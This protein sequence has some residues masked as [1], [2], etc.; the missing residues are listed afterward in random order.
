MPYSGIFRLEFESS[1]VIF[2]ISTLEFAKPRTFEKKQKSNFRP[3]T[4][5]FGF[6]GLEFEKN[7]VIFEISTVEFV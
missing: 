5:Y 7:I 3:K 1:I 4:S 6:F 2:E